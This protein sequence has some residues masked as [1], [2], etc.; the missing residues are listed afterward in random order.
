MPGT[1]VLS[2]WYMNG[3][4]TTAQ[5]LLSRFYLYRGYAKQ[6]DAADLQ[7]AIDYADRVIN[8]RA[9]IKYYV[10]NQEIE[11]TLHLLRMPELFL[12]KAEAMWRA[13]ANLEDCK[14]VLNQL[15]TRMNISSQA[16]DRNRYIFP[17]PRKETDLNP[18]VVPN[19]G[20]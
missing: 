7:K 10:T 12:I 5:A 8:E 1:N 16:T 15:L 11:E 14:A 9:I 4:R 6:D 3:T 17:I 20:Y 19:D 18:L 13:G 2:H